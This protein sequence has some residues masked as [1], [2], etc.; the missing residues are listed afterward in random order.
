MDFYLRRMEGEVLLNNQ[1]TFC[2]PFY[3]TGL[4][5]VSYDVF[6]THS[7][8]S[9]FS[10]WWPLPCT[11]PRITLMPSGCYISTYLTACHSSF[12]TLSQYKQ[13]VVE[14]IIYTFLPG[15]FCLICTYRHTNRKLMRS[16]KKRYL[17]HAH[18]TRDCFVVRSEGAQRF[19]EVVLLRTGRKSQ[20]SLSPPSPLL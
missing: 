1:G 15:L 11:P 17:W 12:P 7:P 18:S 3:E 10:F 6:N 14:W 4:C 5:C 2:L 13:T 20:L 16:L 8:D 9:A 19:N